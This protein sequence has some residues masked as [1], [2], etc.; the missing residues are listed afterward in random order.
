MD[1]C[2]NVGDTVITPFCRIGAVFL[3]STLLIHQQKT[4]SKTPRRANVFFHAEFDILS[5]ISLAQNIRGKSCSCDE[6]QHPK[7]GSLNWAISVYFEDGVEWIFRSPRKAFGL[8][9]QSASAVLASEAATL[10]YLRETSDL[11]V[12]EVFAFS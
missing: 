9:Q 2:Q 1:P 10:N 3:R 8:Q 5:L 11:P 4:M 12:P 7:S 6:S